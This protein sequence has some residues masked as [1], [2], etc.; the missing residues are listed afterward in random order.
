MVRLNENQPLW[1]PQGSVRAIIALAI[2]IGY[3]VINRAVDKEL[4]MFVLGF[5]FGSKMGERR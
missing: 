4:V 1:M 2:V 3:I 5:Y